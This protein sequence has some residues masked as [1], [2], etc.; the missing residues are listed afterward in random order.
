MNIPRRED[1]SHLHLIQFPKTYRCMAAR[2][3][4]FSFLPCS[5]RKIRDNEKNTLGVPRETRWDQ[6]NKSA[7]ISLF[8]APQLGMWEFRLQFDLLKDGIFWHYRSHS[9]RSMPKRYHYWHFTLVRGTF[10]CRTMPSS[11]DFVP[12]QVHNLRRGAFRIIFRYPSLSKRQH[13]RN[14]LFSVIWL[15]GRRVL[16]CRTGHNDYQIRR[17]LC[18][19][20]GDIRPIHGIHSSLDRVH[21][22]AAV[23]PG[24]CR[25]H[26]QYVRIEAILSRLQSARRL[27]PSAGR[28]LHS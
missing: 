25:P 17:R 5:V 22:C 28:L 7:W 2:W 8:L 27:S 9:V 23:L 19:H 12:C 14:M 3:R 21:D 10:A 18:V 11:E 6:L 24:N 20:H 16:L 15:L 1:D 4:S 13:N 26:I